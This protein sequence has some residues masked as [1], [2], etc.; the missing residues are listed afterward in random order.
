MGTVV[1]R[2]RFEQPAA[3]SS[4]TLCPASHEDLHTYD[5]NNQT[6]TTGTGII[7]L[8]VEIITTGICSSKAEEKG[9]GLLNMLEVGQPCRHSAVLD[10]DS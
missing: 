7:S 2:P 3:G 6:V 5:H 9:T 8:T 4:N 1:M 10:H